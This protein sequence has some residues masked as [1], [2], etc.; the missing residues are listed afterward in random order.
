[1]ADWRSRGVVT[2]RSWDWQRP[3]MMESEKD[4]FR[5]PRPD[6]VGSLDR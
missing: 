3:I 4:L 1:V 6:M 5:P 2:E